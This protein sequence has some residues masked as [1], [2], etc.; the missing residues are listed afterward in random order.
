MYAKHPE[1]TLPADEATIWRYMDRWKFEDMLGS[2]SLHFT[3]VDKLDDSLEGTWGPAGISNA[4]ASYGPEYLGQ[5]KYW[6]SVFRTIGAVNCWHVND[7]ESQQMWD[8]YVRSQ[9]GLVVQ[10]T[11]SSLRKAVGPSHQTVYLG[12]M[13]Y[14]DYELDAFANCT[15][16]SFGNF[17]T[18]FNYKDTGFRHENELRALILAMGTQSKPATPLNPVGT[19]VVVN[20]RDLIKGVYLQSGSGGTDL[21]ELQDLCS[22]HKLDALITMSTLASNT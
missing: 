19:K 16:T 22:A 6:E 5:L 2:S 18:F 9:N 17:M 15:E 21:G 13:K 14:I 10:S 7:S 11:V 4:Y 8:L 12:M 1:L 20:I 3:R